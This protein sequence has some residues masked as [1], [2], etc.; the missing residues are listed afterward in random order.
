MLASSLGGCGVERLP[1]E[2][3]PLLAAYRR[4]L[5]GRFGARL[6]GIRLFGSRARG[7]AEPDADAD[8]AVVVAGLTD[9]ERVDGIDLALEAWREAGPEAPLIHPLL[10][11]DR[12]AA[13]R[14]A[15][16]RRIALDVEHE[17]IPA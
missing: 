1:S 17:G 3:R 11:S 4:L 7:D 2:L 10:W 6:Q 15:A 12:Q 13:D 5:E 16:E 14:K 8:V 9:A